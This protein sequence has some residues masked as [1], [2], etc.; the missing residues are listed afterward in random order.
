MKLEFNTLEDYIILIPEDIND[1]VFLGNM[2]FSGIFGLDTIYKE[3]FADKSKYKISAESVGKFLKAMKKDYPHI[4]LDEF[5]INIFL[6]NY[7][8]KFKTHTKTFL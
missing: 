3:G 7:D 2:M 1:K 4:K 5:K 6:M 8:E